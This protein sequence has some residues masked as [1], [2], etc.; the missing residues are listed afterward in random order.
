MVIR[1]GWLVAA[2]LVTALSAVALLVLSDRDPPQPPSDDSRPSSAANPSLEI[3][4]AD[5]T[6]RMRTLKEFRGKTLLV[7]FWA[8]WCAPCREEMPTLDRLQAK[9]G[10]DAFEVVALSV[11]RG[12]PERVSEFLAEIGTAH[13]TV[14]LADLVAVRRAVG[15]VGLPTTLLVDRDGREVHRIVGPA[16]WDSPEMIT[17]VSERLDL[18]LPAEPEGAE[19]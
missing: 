18:P 1:R 15:V 10:G 17:I 19:P 2:A 4:F 14:Y 11:D 3:S 9:L 16:E 6:G 7:N 8:T 5:S 12:G 13:L